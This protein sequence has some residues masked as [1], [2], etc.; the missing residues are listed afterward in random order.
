MRICGK[1]SSFL[2]NHESPKFFPGNHFRRAKRGTGIDSRER[3][4]ENTQA[5]QPFQLKTVGLK[6]VTVDS[7]SLAKRAN[8]DEE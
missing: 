8:S 7:A 5:N 4:W 3:D 6:R 1:A 2:A